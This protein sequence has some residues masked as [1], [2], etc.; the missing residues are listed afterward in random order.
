M[1]TD[2]VVDPV[3]GMSVDPAHAAARFEYHGRAYYFCNPRCRDRFQAD[4]EHFLHDGHVPRMPSV[5]AAPPA[6]PAPGTARQYTCPMDPEIVSDRPGPCPK[7]GMALEPRDV[8]V[9]DEV[10]PEHA[11]MLRRFWIAV[12]LSIPVV[13]LAMG[14]MLVGHEHW[15]SPWTSGVLQFALTTTVV[16]YAGAPFFLRAW[17][18]ALRGNV[19]MFTLIVIGVLTAYLY[20][21]LGLFA[22]GLFPEHLQAHG[23]VEGYFES[24][25]VIIAL[26]LLGQ[27]LE[28]KARHA[29]TAAV[30]R[31]AGMAPR[32]ARVIGPDGSEHDLPLELVQPDDRVRV[33]P[34]EK[35]P[36]DGVVEDG[37]SAVDESM[38]TGE[39]I[40]V[41]KERSAS[42]FTGTVNGTGTLVVRAGKV[43]ADTL[44]AQIVRHV[45]EAQRTRA[46]V[47]KLVDRVA[48]VFVPTV[49]VLAIGTFAAW[50]YFGGESGLTRG[51]LA[52]VAVLLI[53]CPCAL[54]LATPMAI[55]VAVGRGAEAGILV[56][57]AEALEVLHRADT[58]VVDKTGT[59]TEGKPVLSLLE[60]IGDGDHDRLLRLA[61]AIERGSEHPL[62]AAILRA[63]K[64][65]RLTLP[66]AVAFRAVAGKGVAGQVE[67]HEVR[68]GTEAFLRENQ[69]S[70]EG[71]QARVRALAREVRSVLLMAVDGRL[72]A[73]LAVTDP[74]RATAHEAL[75]ELRD[76]GIRVVMVTGDNRETADAVAHL[77]QIPEVH[78][79]VLPNDKRLVIQELQ[80][81]GHVVAMAGDGINDAP[82]L[83]Q[84]DVGLA[85]GT[86][87]DVAM[88]SAGL[89]LVRGDLRA[90]ARARV[91][92]RQTVRRIRQNLFLAFAYN[93]LAIPLAALGFLSPMWAA[94][95]MSLSSLSVVGNSLRR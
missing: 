19:N 8:P 65:F 48:Q 79:G 61:A 4:P 93:V 63:A 71:H 37:E 32:T 47:Q 20:S 82:A 81:Q 27:V 80:R 49:L 77:L 73:L 31:L 45:A 92:S 12:A 42:V 94:L 29:T 14:G 5:A 86:G 78:A 50:F 90:V 6:P 40:P 60:P 87:T 46:P 72:A 56:R 54:G 88:E 76:D 89:T 69:I 67:G 13:I 85:L 30:R 3:C 52:A 62:A 24:A 23:I 74:L 75:D 57:S 58:M 41:V 59:L 9:E 70:L 1:S 25:A 64:L 22:S 35:L 83:A 26:V 43:G 18:A 34:G 10:D 33:R 11:N 36:V 44:L 21:V 68:L 51:M 95:A 16:F 15:L 2:H 53:A 28:G 91:L 66:A 55:T 17:V 7:C 39:P 84:A 38:L